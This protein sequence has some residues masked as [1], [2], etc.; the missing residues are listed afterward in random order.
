MGD[1]YSS[2][3]WGF[4]FDRVKSSIFDRLKSSVCEQTN[5]HRC[6][7]GSNSK[8]YERGQCVLSQ[9]HQISSEI[10]AVFKSFSVKDFENFMVP[11]IY[12]LEN[13][14]RNSPL[15]QMLPLTDCTSQ[16]RRNW[17]TL[18]KRISSDSIT[19]ILSLIKKKNNLQNILFSGDLHTL[20][21]MGMSM[22]VCLSRFS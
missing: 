4:I 22:S 17:K 20:H 12:L 6:D 1:W 18:V 8:Q 14:D 3:S 9:D 5:P 21:L 10:T 11:Y 13:V 7:W 2:H 15:L 16:C 19:W